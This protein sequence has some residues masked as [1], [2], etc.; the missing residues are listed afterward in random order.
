MGLC[1]HCP[2]SE[3]EMFPLLT[4]LVPILIQQRVPYE[5]TVKSNCC[6]CSDNLLENIQLEYINALDFH[7][8]FTVR[9]LEQL[10]SYGLK[11]AYLGENR[12]ASP[13]RPP[14]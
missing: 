11:W 6:K 9:D 12:N 3:Q 8:Q 2:L 5:M 4:A 10:L 7:H 14:P 1:T 13:S